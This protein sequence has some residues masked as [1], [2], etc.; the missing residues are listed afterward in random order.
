MKLLR[1]S[2]LVLGLSP[3]TLLV[4]SACATSRPGTTPGGVAGFYAGSLVVDGRSFG[5]ALNVRG[6]GPA[7]LRGVF[8]TSSPV[9]IE[10]EADGAVMDGLMRIVVEYRTPDGCDGRIQG[11]LDVTRGGDALDGPVTISDC[12]APVAGEL[13][14]RRRDVT[15][16]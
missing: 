16:R 9:S 7:R 3:V 1:P 14:L 10:G 2:L 6:D 11:I 13:T 8:S 5:A 12:D 15:P 4:V